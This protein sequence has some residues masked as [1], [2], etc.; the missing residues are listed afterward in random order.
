MS[1]FSENLYDTIRF[2]VSGTESAR[3]TNVFILMFFMLIFFN[4]IDIPLMIR[5]GQRKGSI[6]KTTA[7]L[8]IATVGVVI[9]D[10]MPDKYQEIFFNAINGVLKGQ[11]SDEML[12]ITPICILLCLAA[13]PIS[14][15]ISCKLFMKGV[16]NYDK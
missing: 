16:N 15:N 7:T 2:V 4:S 6:I 1:I 8:I 12:L 9:F 10:N 3:I 13:Y 11:A 5:F 14:Y